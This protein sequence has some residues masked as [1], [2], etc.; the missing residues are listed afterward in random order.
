MANDV[1]AL[2]PEWWALESL[3]VLN[4]NIVIAGLVNRDYDAMFAKGGDVVNINRT[5]KFV[6]RRKRRGYPISIQDAIIDSDTVKLNQQLHISYDLD[7]R[8]IN[9]AMVDLIERFIQPGATALAEGIDLL[10]QG[11]QFNFLGTVAGRI[12]TAVDDAAIRDLN[13]KFTRNLVPRGMRN[14]IIGPATENEILG[15]DKYTEV[16]TIGDGSAIRNGE[17][18]RVRGFDTFVAN[19]TSEISPTG[20]ATALGAI[21]QGSAPTGYPKGSTVLA[22]DGVT[23]IWPTGSFVSIVGDRQPQLIT[24]HTEDTGN[25]VE[26][27]VWPGLD[28]AVANDAVITHYTSG[29]INYG[30]GYAQGYDG[31]LVVNGF[32]GVN[33]VK[34]GQ[35]VYIAGNMYMVTGINATGGN[36]IGL[37]LNRPL[38]AAASNTAVV[39]PVP[40]AN[41]NFAFIRDALTLV[42]RPMRPVLE[43]AGVRSATLSQNG[44]AIRITIGYDMIN[45]VYK[46]T[47]DTLCGVKTLDQDMGGI[48]LS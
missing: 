27:V 11:E 15:L 17:I 25:T 21:N 32:T 41:Y 24:A 26:I 28:E 48:L 43:G 9:S 6:A 42:Q 14:L 16:Q 20:I 47:M 44:I 22:I 40:P 2:I 31:E 39:G 46:V 1:Q 34:I 10:L 29:A 45:Q 3:R 4:K 12:G 38:D 23:G 19:Q 18:G 13:E 37:T 30:A 8:D 36:V 5:G 7:D 33:A 35:G